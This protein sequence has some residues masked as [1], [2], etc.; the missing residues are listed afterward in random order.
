MPLPVSQLALPSCIFHIFHIRYMAQTGT[1]SLTRSEKSNKQNTKQPSALLTEK[2]QRRASLLG[3]EIAAMLLLDHAEPQP[4]H[5]STTNSLVWLTPG[6]H[7]KRWPCL[8]KDATQKATPSHTPNTETRVK[9]THSVSDNI[10]FSWL[11]VSPGGLTFLFG[12]L[13]KRAWVES[14]AHM[15]YTKTLP[16]LFIHL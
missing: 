1:P 3:T 10:G 4:V 8:S 7:P 5:P 14:T 6:S 11:K 9:Q 15:V 2:V 12:T 13:K 16:A